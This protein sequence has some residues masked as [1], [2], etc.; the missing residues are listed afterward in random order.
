MKFSQAQVDQY[1][2]IVN[3]QNPLHHMIVPG[4]FVVD[5]IL[6]MYKIE[7][8]SYKVKYLQMIS[9]NEVVSVSRKCENEIMVCSEEN[10]V[11]LVIIKN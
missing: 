11:K 3:D 9:V 2:A 6:N 10:G 7:W 5:Y 8:Q 4:Q 1:L